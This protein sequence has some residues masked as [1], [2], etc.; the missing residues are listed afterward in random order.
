VDPIERFVEHVVD[1]PRA[2]IP[3]PAR[4]ALRRF[5]LDS[6]GVGVAGSA[7]PWIHEVIV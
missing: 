5:L 3:A 2:A 7:G 1:T 4:A 6:L